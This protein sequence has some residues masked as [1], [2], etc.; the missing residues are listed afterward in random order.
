[1]RTFSWSDLISR[2]VK[3]TADIKP[4]LEEGESEVK[5]PQEVKVFKRKI[6]YLPAVRVLSTYGGRDFDAIE[7]EYASLKSTRRPVKAIEEYGPIDLEWL[8]MSIKSRVKVEVAHSISVLHH[9]SWLRSGNGGASGLQLAACDDLTEDLLDLLEDTAFPRT[10]DEDE[11]P[12]QEEEM[13]GPKLMTNKKLTRCVHDR[14]QELFAGLEHDKR[15]GMIG[16][17]YQPWE[18]IYTIVQI[19]ANL[20]SVPE[21]P[22]WY[23]ENPRILDVIMRVCML[24][25]AL[26][27]PSPRSKFLSLHQLLRVR[28]DALSL[29]GHAGPELDLSRNPSRTIKR[30]YALLI[31]AIMDGDNCNPPAIQAA[32]SFTRQP[33]ANLDAA[34]DAF[35]RIAY[36]DANREVLGRYIPDSSTWPLAQFLARLLP[37]TDNDIA[38]VCQ[39]EYWMSFIYKGALA[40]YS[41]AMFAGTHTRKKMKNSAAIRVVLTR[42]LRSS[43]SSP[44]NQ[45]PPAAMYRS[46]NPEVKAM[47][48]GYWKRCFE[49]LRVVDEE[50]VN[51]LASGMA[52]GGGLVGFGIGGS[53]GEHNSKPPLRGTGVLG[54]LG[55]RNDLLW[56]V[57]VT[58]GG[59]GGGDELAF[60]DWD[61]M[62]R[63]DSASVAVGR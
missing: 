23:M 53:Y 31:A 29:I 19:F 36:P 54:G 41:V 58:F 63:V 12:Q 16:P 11:T 22:K 44:Q 56:N 15:S 20:S 10:P 51:P 27:D 60:E 57:M 46:L 38:L 1:M 61:N 48:D 49:T 42:F 37:V 59:Q 8:V 17:T 6:E 33:S 32:L 39:T 9:I 4:Q 35:G 26:D 28:K 24:A 30:L 55:A 62:V 34:L 50:D 40:L 43:V 3:E 7:G 14:E 45:G 21:N 52:A 47:V 13:M 2:V 5:S 25:P 18:L